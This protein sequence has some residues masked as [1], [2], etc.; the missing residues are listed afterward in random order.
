MIRLP[1]P[2]DIRGDPGLVISVGTSIGCLP[3]R[4]YE[5]GAISTHALSEQ[6][7]PEGRKRSQR[8][9]NPSPDRRGKRGGILFVSPADERRN[10]HAIWPGIRRLS[11][12]G[13]IRLYCGVSVVHL[14]C[15][16]A[17]RPASA[18]V[19]PSEIEAALLS[20]AE[21]RPERSAPVGAER[22]I[23][24]IAEGPLRVWTRPVNASERSA[25][26]WRSAHFAERGLTGRDPRPYPL[27]AS[28]WI[29]YSH[30]EAYRRR[31]YGSFFPKC[32]SNSSRDRCTPFAVT[33]T[34][35]VLLL[36]SEMLA[37][38]VQPI[39]CDPVV[40]LP[41]SRPKL[42]LLEHRQGKQRQQYLVHFVLVV[43]HSAP[44]LESRRKGSI[45]GL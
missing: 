39:H 17:R 14:L 34:D 16:T 10:W 22:D 7:L 44:G 8:R 33:T 36:G 35:L 18:S 1:I 41:R 43:F 45:S 30:R 2:Q 9:N 25:A 38:R 12:I 24:K 11:G 29:G 4:A 21:C 37:L 15:A 40:P 26:A 13:S 6:R 3:I 5:E 23:P 20:P 31:A 32:F 28:E 42:V 19:K 27:P